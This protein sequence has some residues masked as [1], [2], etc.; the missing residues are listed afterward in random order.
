[1]SVESC[2]RQVKDGKRRRLLNSGQERGTRTAGE[3]PFAR[4]KG[5]EMRR[6]EEMRKRNKNACNISKVHEKLRPLSRRKTYSLH[7]SVPTVF[8][9]HR[10]LRPWRTSYRLTRATCRRV[11]SAINFELA[12]EGSE[13]LGRHAMHSS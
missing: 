1:M 10:V 8:D 5:E 12:K 3:R 4:T 9:V 6:K 2:Y 7:I 11:E 13:G